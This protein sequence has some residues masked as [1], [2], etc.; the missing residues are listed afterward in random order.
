MGFAYCSMTAPGFATR[1]MSLAMSRANGDSEVD[2]TVHLLVGQAGDG[3]EI[4]SGQRHYPH[5]QSTSLKDMEACETGRGQLQYATP[6]RQTA[7]R[8]VRVSNSPFY[9]IVPRRPDHL[10]PDRRLL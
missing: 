9:R 3:A 8:L 1:S 6:W 2:L 10:G 7:W 4:T 5:A